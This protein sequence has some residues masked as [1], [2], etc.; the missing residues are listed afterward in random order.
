MQELQKE[1]RSRSG[2]SEE[3]AFSID[4]V[5]VYDRIGQAAFIKL[6]TEFY[7]RVYS[8]K[9]Q[10]FKDIFAGSTKEEAIQNQYEFFIQRMVQNIYR[11]KFNFW[12]KKFSS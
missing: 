3:D 10:W 7:N 8:D 5:N 1:A 6:S 4:E 2:V 12:K 9:E 11:S